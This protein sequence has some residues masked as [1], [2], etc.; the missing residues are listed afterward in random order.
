MKP[1]LSIILPIYNVAAYLDRCLTSL[2]SQSLT[3]PVQVLLVDDG[4]TDSSYA[5]CLQWAKKFPSI[6]VIQQSN[7]GVSAARNTGLALAQGDYVLFLDPDDIV[8]PSLFATFD[9]LIK[10]SRNQDLILFAYQTCSDQAP[11]AWPKGASAKCQR[12]HGEVGLRDYLRQGHIGGRV[13][14]I[15]FKR[16]TIADLRFPPLTN[17]EDAVFRT[18]ALLR[19]HAFIDCQEVLY[20]YTQRNGSADQVKTLTRSLSIIHSWDLIGQLA[21]QHYPQRSSIVALYEHAIYAWAFQ[22]GISYLKGTTPTDRAQILHALRHIAS[23]YLPKWTR[24]LF[25]SKLTIEIYCCLRYPNVILTRA[26][27]KLL[28]RHQRERGGAS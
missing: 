10:D 5:I 21:R 11:V 19:T 13:W 2:F 7:Q 15:A 22:L 9:R 12:Y 3:I 28:A 1:L 23:C 14:G 26:Y 4:S 8:A 24:P 6:Q 20:G 27:R 17:G 25:H 18:A 16:Q